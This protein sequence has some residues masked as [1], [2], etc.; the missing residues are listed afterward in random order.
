[1]TLQQS[2][3]PDGQFRWPEEQSSETHRLE[4]QKHLS[5]Q[6]NVTD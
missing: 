4:N 1:M 6:K 3:Q 5:T 2:K